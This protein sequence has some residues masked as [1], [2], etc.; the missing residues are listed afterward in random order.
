MSVHPS[1]L[2]STVSTVSPV[3]NRESDAV[4]WLQVR[5][6]MW[7]EAEDRIVVEHVMR[8]GKPAKWTRC[9]SLLPGRS[10]REGHE[11]GGEREGTD[12][13]G[14]SCIVAHSLSLWCDAGRN[15]KNVRE[16]WYNHLDPNIDKRPWSQDEDRIIL[17]VRVHAC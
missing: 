1:L 17:Q 15:G 4:G 16:R 3:A 11:G 12:P 6:R 7:S 8:L 13:C 5:K 10:R 14:P 2:S 9:A